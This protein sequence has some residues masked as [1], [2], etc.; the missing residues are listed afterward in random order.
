MVFKS[1]MNIPQVANISILE[2]GAC[3]NLNSL[4]ISDMPRIMT[5]NQSLNI[6]L[7][8]MTSVSIF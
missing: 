8:L 5:N 6:L 7:S 2:S 1:Q 3:L 4:R